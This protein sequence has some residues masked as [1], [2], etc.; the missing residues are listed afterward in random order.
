MK[1]SETKLATVF[2]NLK[3]FFEEAQRLEQAELTSIG[4][5]WVNRIR[6]YVLRRYGIVRDKVVMNNKDE[7]FVY[8]LREELTR[9]L[10]DAKS[11]YPVVGA[12]VPPKVAASV[13]A[14]VPPPQPPAAAIAAV[15]RPVVVANDGKSAPNGPLYMVGAE[16]A[17]VA[18]AAPAVNDQ[19]TRRDGSDA[20]LLAQRV[21]DLFNTFPN[22][23]IERK[24]TDRDNRILI[25]EGISLP[26]MWQLDPA[27]VE[28]IRST[29]GNRI[30]GTHIDLW[31]IA[32]RASAIDEFLSLADVSLGSQLL[33]VSELVTLRQRMQSDVKNMQ[34]AP[35]MASLITL[36]D[37][38]VDVIRTLQNQKNRAVDETKSLA[39][40]ARV[41]KSRLTECQKETAKAMLRA[42]KF[43]DFARKWLVSKASQELGFPADLI[44]SENDDYKTLTTF[45]DKL[46]EQLKANQKLAADSKKEA[47]R[48]SRM[49]GGRL[50]PGGRSGNDKL[51]YVYEAF[52]DVSGRHIRSIGARPSSPVDV[53]RIFMMLVVGKIGLN[54]NRAI[55]SEYVDILDAYVNKEQLKRDDIIAL[56]TE[57]KGSKS[58]EALLASTSTSSDTKTSPLGRMTIV[59]D[60][61]TTPTTHDPALEA[62]ATDLMA[63][64][65][66]MSKVETFER[67]L[68]T[69]LRPPAFTAFKFA[70]TIISKIPAFRGAP[71]VA[72]MNSETVQ[73]AFS[74]IVA[75]GMR[76][77]LIDSPVRAPITGIKDERVNLVIDH[78]NAINY[79]KTVRRLPYPYNPYQSDEDDTVPEWL[80]EYWDD[81]R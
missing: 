62:K 68:P 66:R 44:N 23:W 10:F 76:K 3:S 36:S 81:G 45:L 7:I 42:S 65:D 38:D 79:L 43:T 71:V 72:L 21:A 56:L 73:L 26:T 22:P 69:L 64:L 8:L 14:A 18:A 9:S 37:S 53:F 1:E 80:L 46:P 51:S 15:P 20:I 54:L 60:T 12:V 57:K 61:D 39:E 4:A 6:E 30:V 70:L 50:G 77:S 58:A 78:E 74:T 16:A 41:F 49:A 24:A 48:A 47:E 33:G 25:S 75:E 32:E 2:K 34:Q 11:P 52:S 29:I 5:A 59:E 31:A 27:F 13:P 17:D 63:A 19:K 40:E 35:N 28:L 67:A 55:N